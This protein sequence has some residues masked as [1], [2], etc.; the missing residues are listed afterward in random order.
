MPDV[1]P[2]MTTAILPADN[3]TE[4]FGH[5]AL[6]AF[7]ALVSALAILAMI[8]A[9]RKYRAK[10]KKELNRLNESNQQFWNSQAQ[11]SQGLSPHV[12]KRS[13]LK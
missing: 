5:W 1:M 11:I 6:P 9:V 10:N 8:W 2:I 4:T 3:G 7:I 12:V 13:L